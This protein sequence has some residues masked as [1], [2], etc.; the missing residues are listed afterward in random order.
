MPLYGEGLR[1]PSILR[2]A[3]GGNDLLS[4]YRNRGVRNDRVIPAGR[5]L[6]PGEVRATYPGVPSQGLVAGGLWYDAVMARPQRIIMEIVRWGESRGAVA[7]N[8]VGGEEVRTEAGRVRGIRARDRISGELLEYDAPVVVNCCGPWVR[9]FSSRSDRD[10]PR[11]FHRSLAINLFLDSPPDFEVGLG[12][13]SRKRGGRTFFLYPCRGGI[14]AGTFHVPLSDAG[15]RTEPSPAHIEAF[16]QELQEAAP[17]VGA[18][19]ERVRHVQWGELPV[20]REGTRGLAAREVIHDHGRS[21]G[22][23]GLVSV[24]GV[25]FTVARR[26]A[27]RV[28]RR[29]SRRRLI[30]DSASASDSP[31]PPSPIPTHEEALKLL[32]ADSEGLDAVVRQIADTESVLHAD[33]LLLRRTDWGDLGAPGEELSARVNRALA[34]GRHGAPGRTGEGDRIPSEGREGSSGG[35]GAP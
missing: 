33:D 8:Y 16:V 27:E 15:G 34:G 10:L 28:L 19:R 12:V 22:P 35:G 25:K 14:L 24:S 4:G 17:G 5:I 26:V 6:S 11:M 21:G 13:S 3:L 7:F 30:P 29:L 20:V 32:E 31:P 9:D 18:S 2:V 23:E 1:R